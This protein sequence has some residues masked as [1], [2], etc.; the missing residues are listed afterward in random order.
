[1]ERRL[2]KAEGRRRARAMK[3]LLT[4]VL[5]VGCVV[6][7]S[8]MAGLAWAQP[9]RPPV[10]RPA[11]ATMA[12]AEPAGA[13]TFQ[14]SDLVTGARRYER[15]LR[16]EARPLAVPLERAR[17]EADQAFQR[18]DARS[19]AAAYAA[20]ALATPQDATVWMRLARSLAAIRPTDTEDG[21]AFTDNAF[22]AAY[23]AYRRAPTRAGEA[24]ALAFLARQY[25]AR[26]LWSAALETM[27]T[28]LAL[29]DTPEERAFYDKLRD[30]HG[31]R[32][33]DYTVESDA[34]APRVC[35]QFSDDLAPATD[36]SPFLQV[37]DRDKPALTSEARQICVEGLTHGEH[38]TLNVRP[39]VPAAN[40]ERTRR[41]TELSIYVRDRR[42][43]VHF[44]GR[45]YVLPRTGQKG[46]PLVS[47]NTRAVAVNILR[48]GDRALVP[49]AL[50][51]DFRQGLD[52]YVRE[53]LADGSAIT[54]YSGV[55]EVDSPLNTDVTTAVPITEAVGPLLPGV[56]VMTAK[57]EHE[58]GEDD[59]GAEATQWFIVSDLGLTALS[60][61]DGVHVLVRALSSAEPMAG[62]RLQLVARSNEVL[63]EVTTDAAGY[64]RFDPGLSRGAAGLEPEVVIA[65]TTAGDYAFLSLKDSAFDLTD[66]GVAGREAPRALDAFL[67]SERG[68]YRSGETVHLTALLRD[69]QGRASDVPVTLVLQ[70]PDGVE[71][72][73]LVLNPRAA[74]GRVVDLD[75]LKGAMTGT[76]RVKAFSDPKAAAI[77]E[78]A[79]LVEDY[80]P[81]RVEFTL[82]TGAPQVSRG[83]PVEVLLE[84]RFLF[85]APAAALDVEA[86]TEIRLASARKGF[87]GYRFGNGDDEVLADRQPVAETPRTDATGR[88][89][90]RLTTGDLPRTD[91]PLEMQALVRLVE[92]GGRAVQRTLVL[93]VA[94]AGSVIGVK[95]LF[96]DRVREGE[97]ASFDVVVAG[98]DDTLLAAP[99]LTWRL[100]RLETRYQW[101]KVGGSWDYEPVKIVSRVGEGQM[102]A[103]AGGPA[104]LT[105][106]TTYGRYRLDLTGDGLP[107][108]SFYFDAGFGGDGTADTPDKLELSLDRS[109]Y[110][111]GDTVKAT[112]TARTAGTATV[113]VVNE[114]LLAQQTL[115]VRAGANGVS[116]TADPSWGPGAY[117]V[118]FMHRPLDVAAGRMP[119]R[120]IGL[121]WFSV[122]RAER[123]LQVELTP[124][125]QMRPDADLAVPV[126]VS[127]VE[128]GGRAFITIAAVDVGILNLT[129]FKT[130]APDD[131]IFG[132]RRLSSEIRDLYGALIDGMQGN[133]GRLRSG[134]DGMEQALQASPPTQAPLALFSGIVPVAADGTALVTFPIPAFDGTVR[135][136]AMA[137]SAEKLGHAATDV[138]VRDK[139]VV[140]ATLP[141]FLAAGDRSTLTLDLTN[142][143]A[144]AGTYALDVTA[145]GGA[146]ITAPAPA[147][148]LGEKQRQTLRLPV[149]GQSV[150]PAHVDV[151][152]SGHGVD[153]VRR[154]AFTVRPAYPEIE[155]R[156]VRSLAPGESLTLSK[157]LLGDVLPGTGAVAVSVSPDSALD[158]PA[159]LAALDRYPYGC[160]EQITSRALPLLSFNELS[161]L[162]G[163][164]SDPDAGG[165]IRDSI[166]R[167][168]AR[169]GS[170]G[171]FGLWAAGGDD[172]WL[173][174]YVADFLTRAKE[175]GYAV[176]DQ[177]F[178]LALDRLRNVVNMAGANMQSSGEGVA[179]A[180]YVLARNGRAPLGDLRYLADT[181]LK[182]L[183]S[184]LA[185]GQVGAALALLGDRTRA[186][187]VFNTALG[188]L[189]ATPVAP[190][191]GRAD[192]GSLLRDAAAL[193][194]LAREAGFAQDASRAL[195]R[196]DAARSVTGRTSTQENAW[197]VLAAASLVERAKA[198][199]LEVNGA[200]EHGVFGRTLS[201]ADLDAGTVTLRN[202]GA[203]PVKVV[204]SV[205]GAPV[206]PEPATAHGFSLERRYYSLDG[207]PA[208]PAKAAQ[209]QRFAVV[210]KVEET[211]SALADILLVD[212]LPAGF[213]I[214]NPSLV[215]G[216]ADGGFAW[217]DETSETSH[218]EFRDDRFVAA[219]TRQEGDAPFVV[220]YV[221]RAVSPG[222]YAHPPAVVE[223][224]YRPDRFA[225]TGTGM[226]EVGAAR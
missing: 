92:A 191:A 88:S 121:A 45:N 224:M 221:V 91:R 108:T 120:A 198:M 144:P 179:Y 6:A 132:Q 64:A 116:F 53:R 46:I 47:V 193:T 34:A 160:S 174:A 164:A 39:G 15:Q 23:I 196:V 137:W 79:F 205:L 190:V 55:L 145:S 161:A 181:R 155:R 192:F 154:F 101:Y 189:P 159:L 77:G 78:T 157:A 12:P 76:W 7:S 143:E 134:G 158:V 136:M 80:V 83:R 195:A 71:D 153:L 30:E 51:G 182:D 156:T 163:R 202:T 126:R 142:V 185:Q 207:K 197:M 214:E 203:E 41:P 222:R 122:D 149:E 44:T 102:D 218:V 172:A 24:E 27:K 148:S 62:A 20:L 60:G 146:R 219:V 74:G 127:G 16:R 10:P 170:D 9:Q 58:L 3:G 113:M 103:V 40:G 186:E 209:N 115:P 73:R 59:Y 165:R 226:V 131:V 147:V 54:V 48:I 106:P 70:R 96:S 95:P 97:P 125:A 133:S 5:A 75:L 33:V 130:P 187:R 178:A 167:L 177:A 184:P 109:A 38:Y 89:T 105:V 212:Y 2:A 32:L 49:T 112:L 100:S 82:S 18:N 206:A 180:L 26:G 135:L 176:P 117:L 210:L 139:V 208:D 151:R 169:Q 52:S 107:L 42:P 104:R 200:V 67:T 183:S 36:F 28:A 65:R 17:R 37:R 19:A 56:Y 69:A 168:M 225:R 63:G 66:R 1:M 110:R 199:T 25:A 29:R 118:A 217:L 86:E 22:A 8:W 124:P 152:L 85:G 141:R 21:S 57:P 14:R 35:V 138:V 129:G 90:L 50:Q 194:V 204:V 188:G 72:R 68:V 93:P 111:S 94:P 84:G 162:V 140:L 166:T 87:D 150:G 31:F 99:G 171:S 211:E 216:G 123:T 220:A 61:Q 81:D 43:G 11:P 98:V 213:E 119:G 114:G 223:D 215:Q 13:K 128:P 175:K 201:R 173:D 4:G